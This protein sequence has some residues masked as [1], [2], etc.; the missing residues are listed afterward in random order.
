MERKGNQAYVSLLL[1]I[2]QR[3]ELISFYERCGYN[4]TDEIEKYPKYL[5]AGSPRVESIT[6]EYFTKRYIKQ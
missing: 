5:N 4:R 1:V 2:S 6:V 3:S